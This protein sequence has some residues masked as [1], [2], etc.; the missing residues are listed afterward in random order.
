MGTGALFFNR[1]VLQ[2]LT[3]R[4]I[5]RDRNREGSSK[6]ETG[7]RRV[8]HLFREV[9]E[10]YLF[11]NRGLVRLIVPLIVEQFLA[12][13]VGLFDSI[14]VSSVGQAAVSAVSLIDNIMILIIN[15]F[16]ALSTGGAIIAGQFLGRR[17]EEKGCE[18][19]EQMLL[20]SAGLSVLIMA[21]VYMGQNFILRVVFGRIEA[22][23][24]ANCRTYL[25]IVAASIPFIALYN[26]GAAV[27][28]GMGD[29]KTSM[30]TALFMNGVNLIGNAILLYGLK[31]GI[32]GAAIPT[33]ISRALAAVWMVALLKRKEKLLHIGSLRRIRPH[34]ATIRQI[35]RIGVPYGL[36]NGVFQLGKIMVLSLIAAFGTASIAANAV[37]GTLCNFVILGGMSISYAISSVCAQCVGVRDYEQVRYYIRKLM[38]LS[39]LSVLVLNILVC[40][41]LPLV[42]ALY[43]LPM[44]TAVMTKQLIW[45][46]GAGA[47]TFWPLAFNLPNA[48]RSSNDTAFCMVVALLSMWIFRVGFSVV[49][50]QYLGMGVFGVWVAMQLDWIARTAAFV[51]RYRG[52]RW[53]LPAEE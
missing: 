39:Y 23:V 25:L 51:P 7:E 40:L 26:A 28:R 4:G 24:M 32:E 5:I 14:M 41:S 46:H 49:L 21:L 53:Y 44:E 6:Q 12:I 3:G 15:I 9:P 37:S 19:T 43:R 35:L 1:P 11:S 52:K 10:G 20:V 16:A 29:S 30:L 2:N 45:L 42:F 50:A 27:Y 22:D 17:Q 33:L 34:P 48:L 31:W 13:S 38:G 36:E 18:A 47:L 8:K